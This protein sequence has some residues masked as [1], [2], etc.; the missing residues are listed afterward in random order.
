MIA[1]QSQPV[2]VD[3]DSRGLGLL[4]SHHDD[5]FFMDWRQD[6]FPKVLLVVGGLGDLHVPNQE[7]DLEAPVLLVIPRRLRHRISDRRGHPM[8]I[9]GLCLN[10]CAFPGSNLVEAAL[11]SLR[12]EQ[13]PAILHPV[14]S[15]FRKILLEQRESHQG[16]RDLQ[17]AMVTEI[18]VRLARHPVRPDQEDAPQPGARQRVADYLSRLPETFWEK[19]QIDQVARSLGLSRRHFTQL[20]R[21]LSGESWLERTTRLRME[22]AERLLRETRLS[23]RSVAFECGYEDISH[24]YRRFAK[25]F[26]KTP[27]KM[28]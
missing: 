27:G 15:L 4:E 9:Y 5:G 6:P 2:E 13:A 21:E 23:I 8:S 20:F 19:T 16:Y 24:F 3:F 10:D 12:V 17:L 18:L 22:H 1:R 28:R 7:W 26:G 25:Y 14:Q 11:S